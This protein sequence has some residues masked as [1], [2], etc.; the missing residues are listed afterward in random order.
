MRLAHVD[1][2]RGLCILLVAVGHNPTLSPDGSLFTQILG[3]FRM[4][5]MFFIA[6]TFFSSQTPLRELALQKA[7]ALLKPFI[8][9]AALQAPFRFAFWHADPLHYLLGVLSGS[10]N[11]LPWLY[12]LWFLPHLWLLFLFSWCIA[13]L[14]RHWG[15]KTPEMLMLMGTLLMLGVQWLPV[16][17]LL[18]IDIMGAS[19]TLQGLPFAADLLPISSFFFLLG[20]LTR[21][22]FHAVHFR[23]PALLLSGS[24]LAWTT[25]LYEPHVSLFDRGY[26]HIFASTASALAG[27]AV[28]IQLAAA[29]S[30]VPRLSTW[31]AYCGVNS[32]FILMFHSPIQNGV[33]RF[34]N[35]SWGQNN[36]LSGLMAYGTCIVGSLI[37]AH[38][39]R[40]RAWLSMLFL[41]MK[42]VRQSHPARHPRPSFTASRQTS[43]HAD[44]I[45]L[46]IEASP[47]ARRA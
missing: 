36:L 16:F 30:R 3:T 39:I 22:S 35:M 9:M 41:P 28:I 6:G 38:M 18:P 5:L 13:R 17:W 43:A 19:V 27:S 37:L 11:H 12:A 4:P 24:V 32:L 45:D 34:L 1:I 7:D 23:W 47:I 15:L 10:G 2:A 46:D 42:Q 31:L 20:M 44:T 25:A 40:R 33:R 29:L 21:K 8:V 14:S 26:S